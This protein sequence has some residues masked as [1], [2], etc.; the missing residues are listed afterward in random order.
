MN[1]GI[2]AFMNSCERAFEDAWLEDLAFN[3]LLRARRASPSQL[4][5]LP[6]S[7]G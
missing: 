1:H 5:H 7:F 3:H 4:G 2:N 6:Q